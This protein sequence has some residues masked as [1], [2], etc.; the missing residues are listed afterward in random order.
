M[1]LLNQN[2]EN[3]EEEAHRLV[4]EKFGFKDFE[5]FKKDF[6]EKIER[7][8]KDIEEGHHMSFEEFRERMEARYHF[9]E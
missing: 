3:R 4:E 8:H 2:F 1:G 7:A 9:N 5:S 6:Y